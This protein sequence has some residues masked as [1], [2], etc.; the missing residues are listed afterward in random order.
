MRL[1]GTKFVLK[2]YNKKIPNDGLPFYRIDNPDTV[3]IFP[4]EKGHKH[5]LTLERVRES[6][7]LLFGNNSFGDCLFMYNYMLENNYKD[8]PTVY[9]NIALCHVKL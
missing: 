5:Y 7:K 3:D 4:P 9:S 8:K 2:Y 1:P 6:A